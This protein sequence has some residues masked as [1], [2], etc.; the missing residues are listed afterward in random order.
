MHP[1]KS[2]LCPPQFGSDQDQPQISKSRLVPVLG[3]GSSP[4]C[5]TK[6]RLSLTQ[7]SS[8]YPTH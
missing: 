8:A 6:K 1:A 2:I 4:S 5:C 7:I 3:V